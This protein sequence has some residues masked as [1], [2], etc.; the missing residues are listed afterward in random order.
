MSDLTIE[1]VFDTHRNPPVFRVGCISISALLME[2]QGITF[3][4]TDCQASLRDQGVF[5][6]IKTW[7]L[8]PEN[9]TILAL[10]YVYLQGVWHVIV[11]SPDLPIFHVNEEPPQITPIY[12]SLYKTGGQQSYE[13]VKIRIEDR[14]QRT[15]NPEEVT[16]EQL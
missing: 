1:D 7:L 4:M 3:D 15:Y 2:Q 8:L 13:L 14:W 16:L 11:D 12:R 9:Y 5:S 10:Y 6:T